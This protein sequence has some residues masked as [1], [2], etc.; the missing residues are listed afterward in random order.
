[1]L[2]TI[3]VAGYIARDYLNSGIVLAYAA[4][5]LGCA[6]IVARAFMRTGRR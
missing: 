4:L 2:T 3:F 5:V 6:I 1:M